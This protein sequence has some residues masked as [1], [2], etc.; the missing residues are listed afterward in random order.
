MVFGFENADIGP[1]Y[2]KLLRLEY[3]EILGFKYAE[4]VGFEYAEI[5]RFE[6]HWT[7]GL[8]LLT[9]LFLGKISGMDVVPLGTAVSP[10]NTSTLQGVTLLAGLAYVVRN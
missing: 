8:W 9:P 1:E 10:T 3:V 4:I 7:Y 6:N 2:T 5:F